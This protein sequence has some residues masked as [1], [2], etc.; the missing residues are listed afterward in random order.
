MQHSAFNYMLRRAKFLL[1][2]CGFQVASVRLGRSCAFPSAHQPPTSVPLKKI[3]DQL[4]FPLMNENMY[5][6]VVSLFLNRTL[7]FQ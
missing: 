6:K 5:P 2:L 7:F 4:E 1:R 3:L